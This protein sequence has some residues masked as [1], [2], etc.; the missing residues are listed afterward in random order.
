MTENQY[1]YLSISININL[2]NGTCKTFRFST[3][4]ES[5]ENLKFC[6]VFSKIDRFFCQNRLRDNIKRGQGEK[7][8]TTGA[9]IGCQVGND[10][11]SSQ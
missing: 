8:T 4:V 1:Q 11:I 5:F 9:T 10:V 2:S 7:K 6:H 3:I